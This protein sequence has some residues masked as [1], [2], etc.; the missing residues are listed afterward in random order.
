M[1]ITR[2]LH[3][4]DLRRDL[5]YAGRTMWRSPGFTAVAVLSLA[6]GIA[7]NTAMFSVLDVLTLRRL[8]VL[9]PN[10][11]V[12]V[13]TGGPALSHSQFVKF[14]DVASPFS[15]V[16]AIWTID[17][18]NVTIHPRP[19][20]AGGADPDPAQIRVGLASADY[21]STL[22]VAFATGQAFPAE[23]DRV[24]RGDS[25]AVI[26]D[27][28]WR[29]RFAAAPDVVGRTFALN[30]VTYTIVGVTS[31][32]FTGEWIGMPTDVW[33]PFAMASMVMPEVPGGPDR[34]PRRVFGR[35]KPGVSI[36]QARAASE[37]VYREIL[38]EEIGPAAT[39][40]ALADITRQRL[41]LPPAARGYSP[42]RESFAQPLAI[43]A[44]AVALLLLIACANLANML[45]ARSAARQREMAVR[46]A[47]GAGRGRLIRQML[48]ESIL[49]AL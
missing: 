17:R 43:L 37:T 31:P 7:A 39:P 22:G 47:I 44:T 11:P 27:A 9:E 38:R 15:G 6:I 32:G 1:Q 4:D 28:Y 26:S 49:I 19:H 36:D 35:L 18:S 13:E 29:R 20:D 8:P 25:A 12:R 16:A 42:Q 10:R 45:L 21:F 2:W 33:V 23:Y 48:T 30:G 5:S 41:D 46:L 14:R 34:F 3:V 24:A 40:Q